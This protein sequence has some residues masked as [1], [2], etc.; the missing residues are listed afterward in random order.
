MNVQ[1]GQVLGDSL[2]L[3]HVVARQGPVSAQNMPGIQEHI[4][5]TFFFDWPDQSLHETSH[6]SR[7]FSHS[8][9]YTF[10]LVSLSYISVDYDQ[11]IR[12]F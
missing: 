6:T 9:H 7:F 8:S 12:N 3:Y 1:C 10:F 5:K 2:S 11:E 4:A